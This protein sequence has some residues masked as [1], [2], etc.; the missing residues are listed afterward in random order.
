M[1]RRSVDPRRCESNDAAR[2]ERWGET[3]AIRALRSNRPAAG[4]PKR[5]GPI[6]WD[7][8]RAQNIRVQ[9]RNPGCLWAT[10]KVS[11]E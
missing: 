3:V 6:Y 2:R 5:A 9:G 10:M 4:S 1:E 7:V 11:D 8:F